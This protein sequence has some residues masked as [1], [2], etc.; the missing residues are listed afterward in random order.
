MGVAHDAGVQR[1]HR[2][3]TSSGWVPARAY[4]SASRL[5]W[6]RSSG[7][8]STVKSMPSMPTQERDNDRIVRWSRFPKGG[9][10]AALEV[11][12]VLAD[13]IRAFFAELR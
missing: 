13:E 5:S 10:F 9:H 2:G 8:D 7:G 4:R 6:S 12:D 11:P 3:F 1:C